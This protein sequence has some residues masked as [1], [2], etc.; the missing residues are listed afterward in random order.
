VRA[1]PNSG[2]RTLCHVSGYYWTVKLVNWSTLVNWSKLVVN[3]GQNYKI[4]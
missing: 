4:G 1:N 2:E 3:S